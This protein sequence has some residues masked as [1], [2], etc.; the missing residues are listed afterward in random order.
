MTSK[1][2]RATNV[3]FLG[4]AA[5]FLLS[6][7]GC[8]SGLS[9]VSIFPPPCN[10]CPSTDILYAVG[11]SQIL[12]FKIDSFTGT[13]GAPQSFAGPSTS[14]GILATPT[15]LYVSDFVKDA[16]DVFS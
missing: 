1:K 12:A 3:F 7:A 15:H 11:A 9:S 6:L 2:R 14:M 10:T 13:L 5:V 16:V 4:A 8:L